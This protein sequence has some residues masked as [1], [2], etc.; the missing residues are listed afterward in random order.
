MRPAS[1]PVKIL[2][3]VKKEEFIDLKTQTCPCTQE[4]GRFCQ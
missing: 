1:L 4:M 3:G 2:S